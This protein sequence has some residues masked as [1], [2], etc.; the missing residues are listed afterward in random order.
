M[1][2]VHFVC[3]SW[4]RAW[5]PTPCRD[6]HSAAGLRPARAARRQAAGRQPSRHFAWRLQARAARAR[7]ELWGWR[8]QPRTTARKLPRVHRARRDPLACSGREGVWDIRSCA[9]QARRG[10]GF[11]GSLSLGYRR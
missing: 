6:A 2:S 5:K 1:Q 3:A 9:R 11:A 7:P 4:S 8:A 10:R